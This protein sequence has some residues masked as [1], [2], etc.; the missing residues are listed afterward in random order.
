MRK[1]LVTIV[2]HDRTGII[3]EVSQIL[4][5]HKYRVLEVNQTT[6]LGEFAGLFSCLMPDNTNIEAFNTQLGQAFNEAGLAYWVTSLSTA[7]PK[8]ASSPTLKE[9]Y[10]VTLR[11]ANNM[12]VIPVVSGAI[13]GFDINIDN[14]RA[15]SLTETHDDKQVLMFFELSVPEKVN[16]RAFRQALSLIA[17]ELNMEMSL[18]HRDIFEAIHRL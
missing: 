15:I 10:V 9:P 12:S 1:I 18:Q 6:L 17:E 2:S 16:H 3:H 8:T 4:D 7:E 11:G 14:L 13:A 5:E